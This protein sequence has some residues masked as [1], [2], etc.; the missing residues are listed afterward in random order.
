[1]PPSPPAETADAINR[2][3][4]RVRRPEWGPWGEPAFIVV[5]GD[6]D[7]GKCLRG[8]TRVLL[9]T[10]ERKTIAE[11][12]ENR[13]AVDV[14]TMGPDYK[15]RAAPIAAWHRN[16][17]R[18]VYRVQLPSGHTFD[19]TANHPVLTGRGWVAVA[20][21][22][23]DDLIAVPRTLPFFGDA[24]VAEARV[25][26][27]AYHLADGRFV[28][29]AISFTS[30]STEKVEDLR[31]ALAAEFPDVELRGVVV[32]GENTLAHR[33]RKRRGKRSYTSSYMAWLR[34]LGLDG[35]DSRDKF[36]PD[37]VFRL[38][39]RL[40]A[41]FLNRYLGCDGCVEARGNVSF[42]SASEV[43]ARDIA[44][45][46]LRFGAHGGIRT[47][48]VK[49]WTYY[50]W[51]SHGAESV[52]AIRREIGVFTKPIPQVE[53]VRTNHHDRIPLHFADAFPQR[54][55]R[56]RN[57]ASYLSRASAQAACDVADEVHRLAHSDLFW[58]EGHKKAL[59]GVEETYDITV[60][61]FHNFVA[62]DVVVHNSSDMLLSFA[63]IG[64][65]AAQEGG[66]KPAWSLA[67]IDLEATK[68]RR[69][70]H[71]VEEATAQ[72]RWIGEHPE[73]GIGAYGVD[74]LSL[75]MLN[76]YRR[77]AKEDPPMTQSKSTGQ[78]SVNNLEVWDRVGDRV[79]E[80]AQTCRWA[81][82]HVMC[83]AHLRPSENVKDIQT[84][85]LNFTKGGPELPSRKLTRRL[86]HFADVVYIS[87][88]RSAEPWQGVY[89]C[90]DG[91]PNLYMKDRHDVIRGE[92]PL[93]MGEILRH[94]GYTIRRPAGLEWM[95]AV[96]ERTA[97]EI[98]GGRPAAE[99][100]AQFAH[101]LY[102]KKNKIRQH[103][104]WAVH[105]DGVDRALLRQAEAARITGLGVG[106]TDAAGPGKASEASGLL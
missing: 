29:S 24:E 31:A 19:A 49:G 100:C 38:P 95:E 62:N 57:P 15:F 54:A 79:V 103:I 55:P 63:G 26:A 52:D 77:I 7:T 89:R 94:A 80:F 35:K 50:E 41:I 91:D 86:P 71:Y 45:L 3:A 93:N 8:D 104:W 28:D 32:N 37:F 43:L 106:L 30:G 6:S 73:R 34:E 42:S 33:V 14:V 59:L 64:L 84:G 72:A 87:E 36:V 4:P 68:Q 40:L 53:R 20:D 88:V 44:H 13:L 25:K 65:F 11:I 96:A 75:L 83:G 46:L 21:L 5:A 67:R 9:A 17:P 78:W 60:P 23:A 2:V 76:S 90:V 85:Q 99:V 51:V 1:M 97:Q 27:L 48:I 82:I 102:Y 98:L 101:T 18:E 92:G 12:V 16:G 61:L 39:R 105:R 58:V 74:D 66:L 56:G 69:T 70:V 22:R 10:G 81:G 47:R